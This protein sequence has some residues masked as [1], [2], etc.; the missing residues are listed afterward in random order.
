MKPWKAL[1]MVAIVLLWSAT[2][3]AQDPLKVSPAN[4]KLV[5]ENAS[6][7]ILRA[8]VAVGAKTAT[9]SHP[10][11]MVI[12]L[13]PSKVRF[14]MPDGKT[15]D[16]DMAN[17]SAMYTP[18]GTHTSAN[19][20]T[21]RA[22]ALV[23]EFKT[24]APGKATLPASR[25]GLTIKP[26]AEGPRAMAYRTTATPTF[27]EAPGT[28]HEF[29]QIVIALGAAQMSLTIDGKPT[30]TTWARGDVQF[31][32]RGVPHEA[33]NVGGKPVDFLIVAIR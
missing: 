15:Q 14:T 23:I 8:D 33:R 10:D 7:R 11:A 6:V 29:D 9:H 12:A 25:E 1:S 3:V 2:A 22:D 21:T 32:G 31:I 27:A 20:G 17:E 18:A 28:K 24:P 19:V 5:V 30:K 26:L 16:S 4:Y 13:G